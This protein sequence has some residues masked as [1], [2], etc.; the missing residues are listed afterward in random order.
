MLQ[1]EQEKAASTRVCYDGVACVA[2]L[3]LS[4]KS[5]SNIARWLPAKPSLPIFAKQGWRMLRYCGF[6]GMF[7]SHGLQARADELSGAVKELIRLRNDADAEVCTA[8]AERV[9]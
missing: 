4:W 3:Y 8:V 6:T 2:D 9:P 1:E 7:K 5:K